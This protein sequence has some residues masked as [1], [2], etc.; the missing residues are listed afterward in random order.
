MHKFDERRMMNDERPVEIALV[1]IN[2]SQRDKIVVH[3]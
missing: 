3:L 2:K 1:I